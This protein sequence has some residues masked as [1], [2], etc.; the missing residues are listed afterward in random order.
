MPFKPNHI[1]KVIIYP[2]PELDW[3]GERAECD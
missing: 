1:V 2:I 3:M